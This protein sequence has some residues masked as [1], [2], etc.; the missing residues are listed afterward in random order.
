MNN[1]SKKI[2]EKE[3][4]F[5]FNK[6]KKNIVTPAPNKFIK[7]FFKLDNL[8]ISIFNTNVLLIQGKNSE[9]FLNNNIKKSNTNNIINDNINNKN[10]IGCDEVG[11]GDYFGGIICCAAFIEKKNEVKIKSFGV[12]DSKLI[13]DDKIMEIYTKLINSNLINFSISSCDPEK[14]N[15]LNKIYNNTHIIKAILHNDCLINLL[16][17]ENIK[18]QYIIM[19]QFVDEKI[20][21]S[22]FKKTNEKKI[23]HIDKFVTKAE[24]KYVAVAA[25]SIIA[26]AYFLLQIKNIETKLKCKIPLG[27]SNSDILVVANNIY[28]NGGLESLKKFVKIDFKTTKNIINNNYDNKKK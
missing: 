26:R 11:V 16:N 7:Y 8:T 28:K 10:T 12:K 25:A 18:N 21:Y 19:D 14:Y 20:Y 24:S 6:Y 4:N 1:F 2:T 17:N 27:S 23:I 5:I 3:V 9:N 15:K 22:Y 13:K